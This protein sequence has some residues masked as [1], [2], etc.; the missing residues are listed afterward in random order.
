M[1]RPK[2]ASRMDAASFRFRLMFFGFNVS[3]T[4]SLGASN[5]VREVVHW[6]AELMRMLVILRCK[7]ATLRMAFLRFLEPL[8]EIYSNLLMVSLT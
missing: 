3:T 5:L 7:S 8:T 4:S 2:L 1:I 6:W